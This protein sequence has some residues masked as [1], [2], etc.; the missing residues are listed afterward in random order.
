M[1]RDAIL[2][3][4]KEVFEEVLDIENL[5][6]LESSAAKDIEEW[7]S[8]TN[9]E[10]ITEIETLFQARFSIDEIEA[11]KNVGDIITLLLSKNAVF[12]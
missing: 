10:I 6:L 1:E 4:L 9:V 7:D 11:I 12:N 5:E 3:K 8:I 2:G